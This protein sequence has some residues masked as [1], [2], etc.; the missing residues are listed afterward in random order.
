VK[1]KYPKELRMC[2]G[3]AAVSVDNTSTIGKKSRIF[4]YSGQKLVS[5]MEFEDIIAKEICRVKSLKR[6][7]K[8]WIQKIHESSTVYKSDLLSVL[9]KHDKQKILKGIGR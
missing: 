9:K 7:R 1:V 2:L 3:I 4:Y 5:D 6:L 8:P